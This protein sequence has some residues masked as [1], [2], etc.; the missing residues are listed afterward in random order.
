MHAFTNPGV[1]VEGMAYNA[2]ADRRSWNAMLTLF[3]EVF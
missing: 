2:V 3:E 1:D